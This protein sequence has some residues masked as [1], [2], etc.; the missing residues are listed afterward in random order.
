MESGEWRVENVVLWLVVLWLV[1]SPT[2]YHQAITNQLSPR[3]VKMYL[4]R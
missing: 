3:E 2:S 1:F 4:V